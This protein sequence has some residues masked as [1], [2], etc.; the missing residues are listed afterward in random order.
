MSYA[1]TGKSV[2]MCHACPMPVSD[3]VEPEPGSAVPYCCETAGV[4]PMNDALLHASG[5]ALFEFGS[6][7]MKSTATSPGGTPVDGTAD[8]VEACEPAFAMRPNCVA[9]YVLPARVT[10][11][12]TSFTQLLAMKTAQHGGAMP[13]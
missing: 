13:A 11:M 10:V 1:V 2:E 4:T 12:F 9:L 8:H 7:S 6:S 5:P 3:G